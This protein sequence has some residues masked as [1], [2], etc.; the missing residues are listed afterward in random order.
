MALAA[1]GVAWTPPLTAF[2][3]AVG[4]LVGVTCAW[5][6]AW[7]RARAFGIRPLA[8]AVATYVE[9]IRNTPYIVQLFFIF[10]GLPQ[11]VSSS[12]RSS[13]ASSR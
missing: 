10:F 3:T 4:G 1:K 6:W 5:A 8:Y 12:R 2:S 7:A 11:P 9:L 13:R